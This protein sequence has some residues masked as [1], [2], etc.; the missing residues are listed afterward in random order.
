[1][2]HVSS[3]NCVNLACKIH[4]WICESSDM[5]PGSCSTRC[6]QGN[7]S[8]PL[9]GSMCKNGWGRMQLSE[10]SI[11]RRSAISKDG[12]LSQSTIMHM[13]SQS[14]LQGSFSAGDV[15]AHQQFP[16]ESTEV[17]ASFCFRLSKAPVTFAGGL[18]DDATGHHSYTMMARKGALVFR[19]QFHVWKIQTMHGGYCAASSSE[20]SFQVWTIPS[21]ITYVTALRPWH[22]RC[23]T[24]HPHH[25]EFQEGCSTSTTPTWC[26]LIAE[27]ICKWSC[28]I[29]GQLHILD[30]F[31]IA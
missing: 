9:K 25:R 8:A 16:R 26:G 22:D 19:N 3:P 20:P 12:G 4:A 7:C 2:L 30:H 27:E 6:R 5:T 14:C 24:Q 31:Q 10:S 1:M 29:S 15:S 28:L 23:S 11:C 17:P 21:N 13:L 18:R